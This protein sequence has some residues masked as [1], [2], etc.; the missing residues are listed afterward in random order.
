MFFKILVHELEIIFIFI[1][2]PRIQIT[3]TTTIVIIITFILT[4]VEKSRMVIKIVF[5]I[6]FIKLLVHKLLI[7]SANVSKIQN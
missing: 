4:K 6:L 7:L 5:L 2:V 3:I 1:N